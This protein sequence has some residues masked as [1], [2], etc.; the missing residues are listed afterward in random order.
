M[1]VVPLTYSKP[2]TQAIELDEEQN[3]AERCQDVIKEGYY[4]VSVCYVIHNSQSMFDRG[5]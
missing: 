5:L 1:A 2:M 4:P 3:S